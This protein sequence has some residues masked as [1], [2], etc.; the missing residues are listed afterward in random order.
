REKVVR[1]LKK[2]DSPLLKGYQLYH[3]YVR[4]HMALDGTTPADKA[5]I[6]I[7]GDNKWLTLIQNASTR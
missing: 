6:E 1:G 4:P 7:Q 3:N 5:G 2:K